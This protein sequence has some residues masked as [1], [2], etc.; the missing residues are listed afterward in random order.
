MKTIF[1]SPE[2]PLNRRMRKAVRRGK[3][4]VVREGGEKL[5]LGGGAPFGTGRAFRTTRSASVCFMSREEEIGEAGGEEMPEYRPTPIE[6]GL[7]LAT[8][9]IRKFPEAL[10]IEQNVKR[11]IIEPILQACGWDSA[12]LVEI[13]SEYPVSHEYKKAADYVLF[14]QDGEPCVLIEA[15]RLGGIIE[16]SEE[17]VFGY[18]KHLWVPLLILTDGNVWNFYISQRP[19]E[20][21]AERGYFRVEL[22][23][24]ESILK[25]ADVF[26]T[27]LGKRGGLLA[28]PTRRNFHLFFRSMRMIYLG[29]R[30][31]I[32]QMLSILPPSGSDIIRMRLGL[33]QRPAT[34]SEVAEHCRRTSE[35]ILQ[36]EQ[37]TYKKFCDRWRR[38]EAPPRSRRDR[39]EQEIRANRA[40]LAD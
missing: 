27:C 16:N 28:S 40:N 4:Q 23:C 2:F 33:E 18:A 10:N 32:D 31:R 22:S 19:M 13:Q 17:Q 21:P 3:L 5:S 12:G 26:A 15:K 25:C 38:M 6:K 7:M 24:D 8:E 36:I 14:N 39:R 11:A 37:R 9:K 30:D 35:R 29:Q 20:H 34:L 1:V